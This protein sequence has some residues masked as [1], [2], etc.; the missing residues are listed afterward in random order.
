[1]AAVAPDG[2]QVHR[3]RYAAREPGLR[4]AATGEAVIFRDAW[5]YLWRFHFFRA[6]VAFDAV[7]V[8]GMA[9]LISYCF[10]DGRIGLIK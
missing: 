4:A 10:F 3:V 2:V 1:M 8:T 7:M 6:F 5:A 9:A